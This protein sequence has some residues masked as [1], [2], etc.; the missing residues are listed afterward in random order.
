MD[1]AARPPTGHRGPQ[2][3]PVQEARQRLIG[4]LPA[5]R[6]LARREASGICPTPR[7]QGSRMR[8]S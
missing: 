8:S 3:R 4:K 2:P 6:G 1:L 5:T 7:R